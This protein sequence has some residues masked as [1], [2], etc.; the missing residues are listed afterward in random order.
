M[1]AEK[2]DG[3]DEDDKDVVMRLCGDKC[4]GQSGMDSDSGVAILHAASVRRLRGLAATVS[5]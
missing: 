4:A 5:S 1:T 2:G 3:D